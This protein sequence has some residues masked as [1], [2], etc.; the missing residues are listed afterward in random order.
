MIDMPPIQHNQG[1]D[2]TQEID[3]IN[4]NSTDSDGT[5]SLGD[6]DL[7]DDANLLRIRDVVVTPAA[8]ASTQDLRKVLEIT[9]KLLLD[10][11]RK[12]WETLKKVTLL[13]A[14]VSKGQKMKLTK[15]DLALVAKEDSIRN[16]GCKA[17][18]RINLLSKE[19]WLSLLLIQDGIKAKLFQFI[20]PADHNMM[21]HKNFGSHFVKGVNNVH[22][23]MLLDVKSCAAAI[24]GLDAKFFI[25][26]YTQDMEPACKSL[27]FNPQG[28]Y[29]K[30]ALVLFPRPDHI[31]RDEF[32]KTA[33]LVYE[34]HTATP[35]LIAAAAIIAIFVLS[36]NKELVKVSDK[37]RIPYKDYHNYYRQS[38]LTGDLLVG[39]STS[40]PHDSW[41]EMF[42]CAMETEAELPELDV[43]P[44]IEVPPFAPPTAPQSISAAM[45]GLAL[46]EDHHQDPLPVA[47]NED[48]PELPAL[49]LE[50]PV[51]AQKPK[52]KPK[53]KLRW[54][55]KADVT[56]N[57]TSEDQGLANFEPLSA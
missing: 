28:L 37:S 35:G 39:D 43:S 47:V 33:K 25:Q 51:A 52:L 21:A 16:F 7:N 2:F 12:H 20:P 1:K 19:W 17:P 31:V 22:A 3:D 26:G 5:D 11:D 44:V 15:K 38:L 30:F 55:G 34:L 56:N 14:T 6:S 48:K 53:P 50:A 24:F 10:I 57:N 40:G 42:E 13:K 18:P 29:T 41:E 9:Q 32:L 27:L 54:K 49:V 8:N 36:S 46:A 23:E 45:Q 4:S